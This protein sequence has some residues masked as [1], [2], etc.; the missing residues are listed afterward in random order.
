[1]KHWIMLVC[2]SLAAGAMP[3]QA[4]D[5]NQSGHSA[6]PEAHMMHT[7]GMHPASSGTADERI[8]LGLSPMQKQ[9]QLSNMRSHLKA[10]Q[11]IVG[12]IAENRFD[13]ASAVAHQKLG[14]TPEMKQM[15]NMFVNKDFRNM[16]LA[17]HRSADELG[18]TLKHKNPV[19][20]MQAL[21]NTMNYCIQC[22]ASYRQ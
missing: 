10:V 4:E 18:D 16:G 14:L 1:M 12:L 20:S 21:R 8:S 9:H 15:C 7:T 5:A 19:E 13:E 11:D 6:M 3:A 22:H 2:I 17:F